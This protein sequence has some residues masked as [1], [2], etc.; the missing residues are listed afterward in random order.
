MY[1]PGPTG[2]LDD[3][4]RVI[5]VQTATGAIW[6]AEDMLN[7]AGLSRNSDYVAL[8][9]TETLK[10][11]MLPD[12]PQLLFIGTFGGMERPVLEMIDRLLT[13]NPQLEVIFLSGFAPEKGKFKEVILK[14][15][16]SWH[17]KVAKQIA[18]FREK[19]L[20]EETV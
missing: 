19:H 2:K 6:H 20:R 13:I 7:R 4:N 1:P 9:S 15:D 10:E 8:P 16:S 18:A 14:T 12:S 17:T 3:P 5:I 11:R